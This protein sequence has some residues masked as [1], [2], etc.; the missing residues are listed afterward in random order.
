[1]LPP[2]SELLSF[3]IP[4]N[5]KHFEKGVQIIEWHTL[6]SREEQWEKG[7]FE[8]EP[9]EQHQFHS[10]FL[11]DSDVQTVLVESAFRNIK[12]RHKSIWWS[13]TTIHDLQ[14]LQTK[15]EEYRK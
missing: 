6:A 7:K 12:K 2:K 14:L 3:V 8:V 10:D 5:T 13:L 1:M 15:G 4:E 11:I 9:G